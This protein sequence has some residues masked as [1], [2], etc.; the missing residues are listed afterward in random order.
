MLKKTNVNNSVNHDLLLDITRIVAFVNVL[1]V[2]F[3]L[4]TGYYDVPVDRVSMYVMTI[5]RNMFM[6]CVPLFLLLTGYLNIEKKIEFTKR[7]IEKY[8]WKLGRVIS[9]YLIATAFILLY[10]VVILKETLTVKKMILN[11]LGFQQY[12]WY[13]DMYV[14]LYVIIPLLNTLWHAI[15]TKQG[16]AIVASI[17]CVLTVMPSILNVYDFNTPG[18][19]LQPWLSQ[20]YS[21]IVS[22]WWIKFYPITY[23]FL[24]AYIREHVDIKKLKTGKMIMA[25]ISSVMIFGIYNIW[26]SYSVNF[27]WGEW[28]GWGSLQNTVNSVLLFLIINSIKISSTPKTVVL[29]IT[30]KIAKLTFG[31]YLLSWISDSIYYQILADREPNVYLRIYYFP[32][33]ILAGM[34]S[35]L[36]LSNIEQLL[37]REIRKVLHF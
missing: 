14:G 23:Y 28:S 31:A 27:I 22:N 5:M 26:R 3:F 19:L 33:L 17:M 37:E 20:N 29:N 15:G 16:H 13:V 8:L 10:R 4:N 18:A 12:A 30:G 35:A 7:G 6:V 2:H 11:I 36:I 32:L 24:G 21:Q 34:V 9:T 25:F 1:S